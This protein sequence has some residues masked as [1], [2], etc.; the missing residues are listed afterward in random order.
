MKC[1]TPPIAVFDPVLEMQMVMLFLFP[2]LIQLIAVYCSSSLVKARCGDS[3]FSHAVVKKGFC[4][5]AEL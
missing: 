5:K 2:A 3:G 4:F 1:T